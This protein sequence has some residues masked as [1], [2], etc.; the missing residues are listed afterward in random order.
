MS[1]SKQHILDNL[2]LEDWFHLPGVDSEDEQRERDALRH[3]LTNGDGK[4]VAIGSGL[5]K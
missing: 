2:D 4:V 1:D 3:E 5:K